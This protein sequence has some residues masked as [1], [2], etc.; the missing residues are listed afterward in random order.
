MEDC[1]DDRGVSSSRK[2]S[3]LDW[4][5]PEM[6]QAAHRARAKAF[7]DMI[8]ALV[9]WAIA[10]TANHSISKPARDAVNTDALRVAPKR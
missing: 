3:T 7:R 10:S 1:G 4:P 8:L 6:L 5:T 2:F 9:K